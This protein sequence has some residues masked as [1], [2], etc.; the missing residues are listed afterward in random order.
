MYLPSSFV[1]L[2]SSAFD[3][4]LHFRVRCDAASRVCRKEGKFLPLLEEFFVVTSFGSPMAVRSAFGL[5]FCALH[6]LL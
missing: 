6:E 5:E 1:S 4:V 3:S 2:S